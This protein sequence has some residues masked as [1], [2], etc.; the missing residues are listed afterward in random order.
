MALNDT[1]TRGK[2]ILKRR[3]ATNLGKTVRAYRDNTPLLRAKT[4]V[5]AT[6]KDAASTM[7]KTNIQT[8]KHNSSMDANIQSTH[9]TKYRITLE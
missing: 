4:L 5:E 7:H 2:E 3:S 9:I 8:Y 1:W 6:N